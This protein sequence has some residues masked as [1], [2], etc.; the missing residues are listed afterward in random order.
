MIEC[1]SINFIIKSKSSEKNESSY[2]QACK[3][4]ENFCNFAHFRN[5][6]PV[7]SS[8]IKKDSIPVTRN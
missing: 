4:I 1:D 2:V 6:K 3:K 5:F 8:G 7:Y